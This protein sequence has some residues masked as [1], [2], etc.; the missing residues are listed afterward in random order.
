MEKAI[1]F[2]VPQKMYEEFHRLLPMR[3]QKKAFFLRIVSLAIELGDKS[4]FA[5][6]IWDEAERRSR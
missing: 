1:Q 5:K 4:D 6:L 2:T 3:G